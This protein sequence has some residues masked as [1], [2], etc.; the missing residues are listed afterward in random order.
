MATAIWPLENVQLT[1]N[2]KHPDP[3]RTFSPVFLK[4]LL[5]GLFLMGGFS[6]DFREGKRPIKRL[7]D[8]A[9]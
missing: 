3:F 7:M 9:H 8:T 2:V 6:G 1:I 5:M 4:N